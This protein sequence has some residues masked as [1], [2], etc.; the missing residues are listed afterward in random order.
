MFSA[1]HDVEQVAED[2]HLK[3]CHYRL[4]AAPGLS[5][6]NLKKDPINSLLYMYMIFVG[7]HE[8]QQ[9]YVFAGKRTY[10]LLLRNEIKKALSSNR[11][12]L[13]HFQENK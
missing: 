10:F 11:H 7:C 1:L 3:I 5:T 6:S 9:H 2:H 13:I 12:K 8:M 4:F